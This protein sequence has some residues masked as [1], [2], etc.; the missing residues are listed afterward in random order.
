M[1]KAKKIIVI[2]GPAGA[3]KT[4]LYRKLLEKVPLYVS[5]SYTTRAIREGEVDGVHY[6]YVSKERFLELIADGEFIEYEEVHKNGI[7]YG[8]P[9]SP[10]AS[11]LEHNPHGILFEVDIKGMV[12]LRHRLTEMFPDVQFISVFIA[13]PS[14]AELKRRIVTRPG[15]SAEDTLLRLSTAEAEMAQKDKFDRIVIND[16]FDTAL[17]E[18][19]DIANAA[20]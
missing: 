2:S 17:Q 13:P 16:D 20:A 15:S 3:G 9:R 11:A 8:T 14:M 6:N 5:V 1:A 4:S 19:V 10:L 12:N 7:L 18:L